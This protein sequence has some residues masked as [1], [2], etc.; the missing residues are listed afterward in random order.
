MTKEN[1]KLIKNYFILIIIFLLVVLLVWYICK[2]YTVYTEYEKETPVIRDTLSYEITVDEIDHFILENPDST[3]YMCT[4]AEDKCRLFEKDFKKL[5]KK[6]NLQD[7]IIYLNLSNAD[8]KTFVDDFNNKYN[9]KIK[10][11]DNYPLLVE[12]IDG[13]VVGIVQGD[14]DKRLSITK[15]KQFIDLHQIGKTN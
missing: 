13:N 11:T 4:A 5:I 14:E 7:K 10:L 1:K 12:F 3:I 6:N 8:V 2:W 15:V 9:Y